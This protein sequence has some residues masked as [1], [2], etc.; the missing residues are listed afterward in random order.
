MRRIEID[1]R[2]LLTLKIKNRH[3]RA[4]GG[5]PADG[6]VA[7]GMNRNVLSNSASVHLC[8]QEGLIIIVVLARGESD[9]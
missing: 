9:G 3:N 1:R 8:M 6:L 7:G 4:D 5:C 2:S